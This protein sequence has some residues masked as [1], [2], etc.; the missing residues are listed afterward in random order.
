M[1]VCTAAAAAAAAAAIGIVMELAHA[2][3]LADGPLHSLCILCSCRE[4]DSTLLH[5]Q[6]AA[7]ALGNIRLE[8]MKKKKKREYRTKCE[9]L[10]QPVFRILNCIRGSSY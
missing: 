2:A 4:R 3:S 1:C 10:L 7:A 6:R 8:K 5:T 9:L